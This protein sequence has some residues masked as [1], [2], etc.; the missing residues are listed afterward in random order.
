MEPWE[1]SYIQR[2]LRELI[3]I[4]LSY[5]KNAQMER[6][7]AAYLARSNQSSWP[8]FF[9]TIEHNPA[10]I[11]RLEEYLTIN[12]SSFF[13]DFERYQHLW[14]VILPAL[15][16]DRP[17]LRAWSA[18]CSR[19]HEP[20]SLAMLLAETSGPY[21]Q[22]QILGTD[23]DR[24]VL[25]AATAGGPYPPNEVAAMPE[26]V[27]N[28]YLRAEHGHYWVTGQIRRKVIFSRHDLLA[29]P[30]QS[31]LD[32]IICRNVVIYF[33]PEVKDRLYRSFRDALRPGGVLFVGGTEIVHGAADIGLQ[34]I[35]PSFYRR[36]DIPPTAQH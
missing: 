26:D 25:E 3:G 8:R 32:L 4:D 29:D 17:N 13:R 33:T 10:E 15:L 35:G 28:Q 9:R 1:Y 16:H 21:R 7:L 30:F 31:A 27:R 18:G 34:L 2:K 11:A 12:V 6:R 36:V 20:Y 14:T 24:S 19:G 23:I 22:H 5:Y